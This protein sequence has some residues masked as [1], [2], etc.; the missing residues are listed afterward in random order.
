MIKNLFRQTS[1]GLIFAVLMAFA[2]PESSAET[3]A[4]PPDASDTEICVTIEQK[5]TEGIQFWKSGDTDRALERFKACEAALK[6]EG[7]W[8]PPKL[9]TG[10]SNVERHALGMT[11]RVIFSLAAILQ[12]LDRPAES[13]RY[14]E[15]ARERKLM[16]RI[17]SVGGK[18][19]RPRTP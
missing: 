12:R 7:L 1:L 16:P 6:Q 17:Y 19:P 9:D 8:M 11:N 13:E 3:I 5:Y 4:F 15:L 10:A 18:L 14:A 2:G